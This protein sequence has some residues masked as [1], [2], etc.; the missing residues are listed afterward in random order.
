V[1]ATPEQ[2]RTVRRILAVLLAGIAIWF[3]FST[4]R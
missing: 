2:R 3:A 1:I 4:S